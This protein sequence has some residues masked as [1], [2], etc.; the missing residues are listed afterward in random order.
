MNGL[1]NSPWDVSKR[2][3]GQKES[4]IRLIAGIHTGSDTSQTVETE[5]RS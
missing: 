1:T 4:C 3:I 5:W 2:L